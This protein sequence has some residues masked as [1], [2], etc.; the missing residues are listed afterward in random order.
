MDRI[1]DNAETWPDCIICQR[2]TSTWLC[3]KVNIWLYHQ[4]NSF[5]FDWIILELAGSQKTILIE[6]PPVKVY[7]FPVHILVAYSVDL[8]QTACMHMLIWIY[9]VYL[10][11]KVA[12]L[13][14]KTHIFWDIRAQLFKTYGLWKL[15]ANVTLKFFIMKYDKTLIFFISLKKCE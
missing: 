3:E 6:L 5:R 10:C 7:Q 2:V 8:K 14:W 15:L 4:H 9:H 13:V 1:S 12:F 11:Q